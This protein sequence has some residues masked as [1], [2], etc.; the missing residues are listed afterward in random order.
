[1]LLIFRLQ[2]EEEVVE[3]EKQQQQLFQ[4]KYITK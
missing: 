2:H 3:E 1:M 4:N